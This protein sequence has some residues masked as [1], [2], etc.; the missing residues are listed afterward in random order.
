MAAAT[1]PRYSVCT[2]STVTNYSSL[3]FGQNYA[4]LNL[5]LIDSL[6]TSVSETREGQQWINST[7]T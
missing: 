7:E 3:T 6:V 5:E 2:P 4:L 1:T